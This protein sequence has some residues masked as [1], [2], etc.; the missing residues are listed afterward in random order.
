MS[1]R[2]A[3]ALAIRWAHAAWSSAQNTVSAD[4]HAAAVPDAIVTTIMAASHKA[5]RVSSLFIIASALVFGCSGNDE[6]LP[7]PTIQVSV[8][9]DTIASGDMV[10]VTV[11]VENFSLPTDQDHDHD[12]LE[13]EP[14]GALQAG[15]SPAKHG[16]DYHGPREGHYHLYLNDLMSNPLVHAYEHEVSVVIEAEPGQHEII[17]R[18]H[19]LDHRIIEPQITDST[20]ITVQ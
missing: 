14:S 19:G 3:G 2:A 12:H 6:E 17:A 7:P 8:S 15:A 1:S 16:D 20:P 5:S 18:L 4:R 10:T 13:L 9:P 11:Q